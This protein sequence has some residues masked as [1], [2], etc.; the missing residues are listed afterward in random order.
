MRKQRQELVRLVL[1][2]KPA[3]RPGTA[4]AYS[5]YGYAI[6]GAMAEAACGKT[7]EALLRE[8]LFGPLGMTTAGFGP[9]GDADHV[10]Q[11]RGHRGKSPVEP[12]PWADN[13]A[14]MGPA[15]TVHAS[16]TDWAQ[17]VAVQLAGARGDSLFLSA[18]A[19][20][21]L[22]TPAGDD[23][24]AA[25]WLVLERPWARGRV[26]V[27]AGSNRLWYAVVWMVPARDFAVLAVSNQGG[28]G[29]AKACDEAA[30]ALIQRTLREDDADAR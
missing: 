30:W 12:G 23:E 26:L 11:P 2:Q 6:A 16:L 29:A 4:T 20:T 27:H 10:T 18:D 14:V 21:R 24:T 13:P 22:Q 17:F 1:Q 8:R 5:N 19:F 15:G 25:G 7:W 3:A 9:P 28:E